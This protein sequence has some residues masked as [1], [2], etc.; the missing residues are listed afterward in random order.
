MKKCIFLILFLP[1]A[2][3]A[4]QIEIGSFVGVNYQKQEQKGFVRYIQFHQ[5]DPNNPQVQ[6][7]VHLPYNTSIN[8]TESFKQIN[9]QAQYSLDKRINIGLNLPY[10]INQRK[11]YTRQIDDLIHNYKAKGIG[12]MQLYI[13]AQLYEFGTEK[14]KLQ[15]R[16]YGKAGIELPTGKFENF[17]D[18]AELEPNLQVGSESVDLFVEAA[19]DL[20][21]YNFVFEIGGAYKWNRENELKWKFG[22]VAQLNAAA[23]YPFKI[24]NKWGINPQVQIKRIWIKADRLGEWFEFNKPE[25]VGR[26]TGGEY[27]WL[28]PSINFSAFN[29]QVGFSYNAL[30]VDKRNGYQPKQ[31]NYWSVSFTYK[32]KQNE[33]K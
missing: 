12:D 26:D 2:L 16:Y 1:L 5:Y 24:K 22:D 6:P 25:S 13:A 3:W 10:L 7:H 17:G 11:I 21:V 32:I 9:L 8:A 4:Q 29:T 33:K 14:S 15:S 23:Y 20:V 27:T 28:S 18:N 31:I 19:A 30:I